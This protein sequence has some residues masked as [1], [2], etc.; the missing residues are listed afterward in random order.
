MN[1]YQ[2]L[3]K[4]DL[5]KERNVSNAAVLFFGKQSAR[6]FEGHYEIKVASFPSHSGFDTILNEHEYSV[7]LLKIFRSAENFLLNNLRKSYAKGEESGVEHFGFPRAMLREA[8]VNLI[9]HRDYRVDVKSTIEVR[10]SYILFYNPAQLFSPTI[11]LESLKRYHP[12][13]P[14]NK[15]IANI[16]Y[17]MG[18]F[19]NWGSGNLKILESAKK[20]TTQEP[21]LDFQNGMFSLKIHRTITRS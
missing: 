19:E 20:H 10:P 16:F 15:L 21:E 1:N 18:L 11:N 5:V 8:L 2:V 12:S 7:N 14:G 9:V 17:M 6:F 4:L 13:R 3:E